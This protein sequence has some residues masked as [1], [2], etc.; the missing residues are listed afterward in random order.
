M[1]LVV[2][3]WPA[4]VRADETRLGEARRLYNAGR[5]EA[6]M[7]E[8][9]PLVET[10]EVRPGALLVL[11]RAGLERFRQTAEPVDLSRAREALRAI[12]ASSLEPRDRVELIVGLGEA[13]Y[14]EESFNAAAQVFDMALGHMEEVGAQS[15][16]QL[17]DWWATA[18]DRY[19][20]TRP[21]GERLVIYRQVID[22]MRAELRR[23]AGSAAASYW[24]AAA[25]RARGETDAAWDAAMSAWV[26]AQLT[27]DRGAALR[28]DV[29]RLVLQG[30]IPDRARRLASPPPDLEQA[31]TS[32]AAEWDTFK[33]R[34][35]E[36]Q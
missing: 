6:A 20:Q 11:G 16:D 31:I 12:D 22:Q 18:L 3:W 33:K 35:T 13:L 36:G 30:I 8:A 27:P 15:R 7:A 29:D 4:P 21:W 23:D 25:L 2:A 24:I 1:T 19:A 28:P 10:P 26:R 5:Y 9:A 17:L 34:W 14:L 32:M